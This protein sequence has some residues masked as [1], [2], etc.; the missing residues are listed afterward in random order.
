VESAIKNHKPINL[1]LN[2]LE[3]IFQCLIYRDNINILHVTL[4]EKL[5]FLDPSV[6]SALSAY[7]PASAL[8][9][10]DISNIPLLTDTEEEVYITP[11]FI[12]V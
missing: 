9:M 3:V 7:D 10:L 11:S 5:W 4:I 1:Y 12:K 2:I 8:I 6:F